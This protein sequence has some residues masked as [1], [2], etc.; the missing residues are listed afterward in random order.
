MQRPHHLVEP[1]GRVA[2]TLV[3][4]VRGA[5][6][7]EPKQHRW[8]LCEH[9]NDFIVYERAVAQHRDQKP[10]V[11]EAEVD[12]LEV[13]ARQDLPASE[14]DTHEAEL[15]CIARESDPLLCGVEATARGNLIG[16]EADVAH[17]AFE[18]AQRGKLE[19]GREGSTGAASVERH[20]VANAEP[21]PFS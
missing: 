14:A 6:K 11:H 8:M 18:V 16:I 5:V 10:H 12:L 13:G 21:T 2:K 20:L 19:G 9:L 1:V 4:V 7:C 15:H 17:L 3:R